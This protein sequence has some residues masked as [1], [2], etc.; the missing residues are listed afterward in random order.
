MSYTEKDSVTVTTLMQMSSY[1]KKKNR[2]KW[3]GPSKLPYWLS[4]K[5]T[6]LYYTTID[7]NDGHG[8]KY[9]PKVISKSYQGACAAYG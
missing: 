2:L 6:L 4:P 3:I 5:R 7:Y 8:L 9:K 1:K